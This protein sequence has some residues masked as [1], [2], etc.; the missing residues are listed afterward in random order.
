[1]I[2]ADKLDAICRPVGRKPK[3]EGAMERRQHP[4]Y[5]VQ[6]PVSFDG[7]RKGSGTI[8][9]LSVSGCL[10]ISPTRV[11]QGDSLDLWLSLP[12][13]LAPILIKGAEVRW[14]ADQRFGVCFPT[15]GPQEQLRLSEYLPR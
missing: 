9:D 2:V 15:L 12:Q 6:L 14:A 11:E 13:E 4:R 1:M 10:V 7:D 8:H 3:H 5:E